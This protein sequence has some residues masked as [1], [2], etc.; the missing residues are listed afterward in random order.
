MLIKIQSSEEESTV[1]INPLF[2][3]YKIIHKFQEFVR[4]YTFAEN[5]CSL[6]YF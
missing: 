2:F 3:F 4:P 6:F 5:P 1:Q